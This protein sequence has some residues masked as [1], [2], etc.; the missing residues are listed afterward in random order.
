M[1]P[2]LPGGLLDTGEGRAVGSPRLYHTVGIHG[3]DSGL[4]LFKP[5]L[6]TG[7]AGDIGLVVLTYSGL[8]DAVDVL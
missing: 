7:D 6:G 1:E 2:G 4:Q 3:S 5:L 8:D